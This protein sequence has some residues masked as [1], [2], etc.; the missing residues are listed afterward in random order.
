MAKV[1]FCRALLHFNQG[2]ASRCLRCGFPLVLRQDIRKRASVSRKTSP[3]SAAAG[4]ARKAV[5]MPKDTLGKSAIL[6]RFYHTVFGCSV[7]H[8]RSRKARFSVAGYYT[9]PGAALCCRFCRAFITLYRVSIAKRL[10]ENTNKLLQGL[11]RGGA[12]RAPVTL[13][14]LLSHFILCSHSTATHDERGAVSSCISR[15]LSSHRGLRAHFTFLTTSWQ[16]HFTFARKLCS[17]ATHTYPRKNFTSGAAKH[18]CRFSLLFGGAG[19]LRRAQ[20]RASSHYPV[21]SCRPL[22]GQS[23]HEGDGSACEFGRRR[24]SQ[25]SCGIDKAHLFKG[26]HR[27]ASSCVLCPQAGG[28]IT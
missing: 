19:H 13:S 28:I 10:A 2:A 27:G 7:T 20:R 26:A 25:Y 16:K 21:F 4:A 23:A 18:F 11:I 15:A 9:Y 24:C 8:C 6:P 22:V 14:A 12:P 1:R 3:L 5:A 17:L